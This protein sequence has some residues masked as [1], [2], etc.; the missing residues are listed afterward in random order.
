MHRFVGL[1]IAILLVC[2][3]GVAPAAAEPS[4]APQTAQTTPAKPESAKW[5]IIGTAVG[6]GSG[7]FIGVLSGIAWFDDALYADR[8]VWT[9][10]ISFA[11]AGAV[12]GF[13]IGRAADK[14]Q[15][16]VTARPDA[17]AGTDALALVCVDAGGSGRVL[18]LVSNTCAARAG[19]TR[20]FGPAR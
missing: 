11:A 12:G 2:N 19:A 17:G 14:R 6:A 3:A 1:A 15:P 10:A 13:F 16:S 20:L 9:T 5:R 7:F 18:P 8:K 4:S